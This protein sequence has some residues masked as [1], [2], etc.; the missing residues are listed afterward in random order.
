MKYLITVLSILFFYLSA[1]SQTILYLGECDS[2]ET[3]PTNDFA[4]DS[5]LLVKH[6]QK[7]IYDKPIEV[8]LERT[9]QTL[10]YKSYSSND[11]CKVINYWVNGNIKAIDYWVK[12]P[13]TDDYIWVYEERFC[14]NGQL[15]RK[16]YPNKMGRKT[17]KNYYC[18]GQQMNEFILVD[19]MYFDGTVTWWTEEGKIKS[20]FNYSNNLKVGKWK[21]WVHDK[22]VMVIEYYENGDLLKTES[23]HNGKLI[24]TK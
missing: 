6:N 3:F 8:Y 7:L 1:S 11:T 21:Y 15:I 17:I 23:Y 14:E 22:N 16:G 24:N 9:K 2:I 12:E 5:V 20:E 19:R 10:L 4:I 13:S 18:N